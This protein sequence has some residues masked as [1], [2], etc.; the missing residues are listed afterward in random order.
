[1]QD[2]AKKDYLAG[3]KYKDIAEKYDVSINTVK[4]WKQ[5][6][7]W[8]RGPTQKGVHTKNKKGAHKVDKVA[9]KIVKELSANDGLNDQQKMF[10]LYYLQRFNATW[11]YMQA[12]DVD[13]RTANVNGPR[14]LG[15]ASVREQIDKLRGEIANDLFVTADDIAK[16]YAKQAFSDIGDYVEF[17]GRESTILDEDERELL[18][19]NGNPIKS[20]RS[21]VMFKDKDK[22]DT[23]LIKTIKSGKDGPVIELYDKQKAM[24]ALMNYVGEKQT[25][26]GQLMQA[27]IDRLKIQ[28]GDN[29]PDEDDDDGF[30]DAIDKSM[31]GVWTDEAKE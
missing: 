7:N 26:R 22:V 10:C 12:Y 19:D 4:S 2:E 13:Y 11:A 21:Y 1:M 3:M 25:L 27:Q 16:E 5:R 8:Q 6:N 14:L 29:D 23:S 31:E 28:N 9:P 24:D 18:D 17:G 15:N 20:H 30:I